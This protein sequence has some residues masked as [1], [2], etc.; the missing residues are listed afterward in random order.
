MATSVRADARCSRSARPWPKK[1][2]SPRIRQTGVVADEVLADQESLRQAARPRLLG[3]A[4]PDAQLSSVAEQAAELCFVA[5]RGDDQDFA[6]AG[7]HQHR[8]RIVDHRFVVHRQKLLA[9]D[10]SRRIEPGA[11]AARENDSL[12]RE[13]GVQ[14]VPTYSAASSM[15][16][17][18]GR[19]SDHAA[20]VHAMA[21]RQGGAITASQDPGAPAWF[22]RYQARVARRPDSSECR[23]RHPSSERS[24]SASM[25]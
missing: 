3:V 12:S 16:R 24:F 18:G 11:V 13:M 14:T 6:D 1:M 15:G 22:S 5:R 17:S 25:A 8:K 21:R 10:E 4:Y 23:G 9:D 19:S 7:Q 20:P 2:L